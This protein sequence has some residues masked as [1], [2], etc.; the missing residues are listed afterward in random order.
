[1]RLNIERIYPSCFGHW[2]LQGF[3]LHSNFA[4]FLYFYISNINLLLKC[5]I[6]MITIHILAVD[7]F[8][9]HFSCISL[10]HCFWLKSGFA[11]LLPFPFHPNR[12]YHFSL[13]KYWA[14]MTHRQTGIFAK[15]GSE[16]IPCQD[17]YHAIHANIHV[18][19]PM[20]IQCVNF[21]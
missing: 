2:V 9:P 5:W 12:L 7:A 19:T 15:E 21:F 4:I 10:W 14:H 17:G 13:S 6:F 16:N 18:S 8:H 1:M 3:T 11:R 20:I